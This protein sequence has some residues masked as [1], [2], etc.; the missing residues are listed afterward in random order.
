MAKNQNTFAKRQRE[1]M[2]KEK[3]Q[4]KRERRQIRKEAGADLGNDP[5]VPEIKDPEQ[6]DTDFRNADEN[7]ND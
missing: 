3:A 1:R 7:E 6:V 4:M 5:E 2:K